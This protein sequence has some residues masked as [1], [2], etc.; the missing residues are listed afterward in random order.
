MSTVERTLPGYFT[1]E[2]AA[3]ELNVSEQR[4]RQLTSNNQL[5]NWRRVGTTLVIPETEV[6]RRKESYPPRRR[7]KLSPKPVNNG[8]K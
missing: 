4:V 6:L 7:N 8:H 5:R 1:V 3:L 2:E